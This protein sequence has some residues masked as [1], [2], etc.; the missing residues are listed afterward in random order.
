M[1][2][3]FLFAKSLWAPIISHSFNDFISA[4]LFHG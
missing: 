4:V 2:L 3:L 1:A